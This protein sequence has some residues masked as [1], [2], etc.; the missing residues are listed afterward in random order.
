MCYSLIGLCLLWKLQNSWTDL[1]H[2]RLTSCSREFLYCGC[3]FSGQL[4]VFGSA[5]PIR[6][7]SKSFLRNNTYPSSGNLPRASGVRTSSVTRARS[8]VDLAI[9]P[10]ESK[11]L[12]TPTQRKRHQDPR[13]RSWVSEHTR[14][15][16]PPVVPRQ[17][18]ATHNIHSMAALAPASISPPPTFARHDSTLRA[19]TACHH[20]PR[21]NLA[22][23]SA[24]IQP[25]LRKRP[26][27]WRRGREPSVASVGCV[28]G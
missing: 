16:S 4:H 6:M 8:R 15:L 27:P 11:S 20:P 23:D 2:K 13:H 21:T 12:D 3:K 18:G 17:Q 25:R 24:L 1:D 7:P 28:L 10:S 5:N 9:A 14:P 19:S 22:N 26:N